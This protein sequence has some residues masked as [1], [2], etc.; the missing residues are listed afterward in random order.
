M[1]SWLTLLSVWIANRLL[2][3]GLIEDELLDVLV[4]NGDAD[5]TVSR[6]SALAWKRE[7]GEGRFGWGCIMCKYVLR[8]CV[9][10]THCADT[11]AGKTIPTLIAIKAWAFI[12]LALVI[13]IASPICLL[14]WILGVL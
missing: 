11:L 3:F 7:E 10:K 4:F 14:L 5:M 1:K 13:I 2:Q 9:T 12:S 6:R 8:W